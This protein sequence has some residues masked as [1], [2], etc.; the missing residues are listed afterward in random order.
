MKRPI[1]WKRAAAWSAGL[2]L[3]VLYLV[4]AYQRANNWRFAPE[5]HIAVLS[6]PLGTIA[7]DIAGQVA[8]VQVLPYPLSGTGDRMMAERVLGHAHIIILP[9]QEDAA[10]LPMPKEARIITFDKVFPASFQYQLL[11]NNDQFF[12]YASPELLEQLVQ[13]MKNGLVDMDVVR[14]GKYDVAAKQLRTR[15]KENGGLGNS[16]VAPR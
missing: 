14:A 15:I 12:V 1:S 3:V 6:Q 8:D 7:K 11:I 16:L 13:A 9:H 10:H 2:L 5:L 4:S